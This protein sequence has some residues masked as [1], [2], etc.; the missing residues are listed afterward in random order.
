MGNWQEATAVEPRR[1]SP[2]PCSQSHGAS[3]GAAS[4]G[5]LSTGQPVVRTPG[6]DNS[7]TVL[8]QK[9][10]SLGTG[11]VKGASTGAVIS[12]NEGGSKKLSVAEGAN[13]TFLKGATFVN[14]PSA[15][16]AVELLI[17]I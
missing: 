3:G 13:F 4:G 17:R 8:F 14:A 10:Q 15:E 7:G 12:S 11:I 1:K 5:K 2:Q 6:A 9:P 16:R